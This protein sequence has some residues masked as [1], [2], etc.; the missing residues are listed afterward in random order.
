M[1]VWLL[2]SNRTRLSCGGRDLYDGGEV[3]LTFS[4]ALP[5]F[6]N[7]DKT[8]ALRHITAEEDRE[9]FFLEKCVLG[10]SGQCDGSCSCI[11]MS[12][13][14]G[15]LPASLLTDCQLHSE[16]KACHH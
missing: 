2:G 16:P 7:D 8:Q 11:L 6:L 3:F 13:D 15:C 1:Y 10:P 4:E 12:R 5:W 14:S 9:N